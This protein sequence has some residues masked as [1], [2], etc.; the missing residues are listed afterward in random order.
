[1]S[2]IDRRMGDRRKEEETERR[3]VKQEKKKK[4]DT[5]GK[6]LMIHRFKENPLELNASVAF[7]NDNKIQWCIRNKV[8]M[9]VDS[10]GN[11]YVNKK[12]VTTDKEVYKMWKKWLEY[13]LGL[14]KR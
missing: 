7:N 2:K 14:L 4:F 10:D 5:T 12:R 13:T 8:V 9:E 11:Y 3:K 6:T 1:M